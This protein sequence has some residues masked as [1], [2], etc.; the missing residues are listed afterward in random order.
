MGR[1]IRRTPN[2]VS[3][4]EALVKTSTGLSGINCKVSFTATKSAHSERLPWQDTNEQKRL[5]KQ[6]K[7][8]VKSERETRRHKMETQKEIPDRTQAN[9]YNV[10]SFEL[11]DSS[12]VSVA[13]SPGPRFFQYSSPDVPLNKTPC[14][15]KLAPI[16]IPRAQ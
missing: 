16:P 6:T 13:S 4:N 15:G 3:N 5:Q 9:G 11:E 14:A 1:P 8:K 12:V 2:N 7:Q 10:P